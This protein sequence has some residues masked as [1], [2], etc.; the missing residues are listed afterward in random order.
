MPAVLH[1]ENSKIEGAKANGSRIVRSGIVALLRSIA[2]SEP[3]QKEDK[4]V[5]LCIPDFQ[6]FEPSRGSTLTRESLTLLTL[7]HVRD[8][9]DTW[10]ATG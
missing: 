3:S 2:L 4:P 9:G 1:A 5:L 8:Y 10:G 6:A 7:D